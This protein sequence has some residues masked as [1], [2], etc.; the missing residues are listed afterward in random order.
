M[1]QAEAFLRKTMKIPI[2]NIE[3]K[4]LRDYSFV[5]KDYSSMLVVTGYYIH[6]VIVIGFDSSLIEKIIKNFLNVEE[7]HEN[8]KEELYLDASGEVINII[9]G[10]ANPKYIKN[11]NNLHMSTPVKVNSIDDII[12]PKWNSVLNEK[13]YTEYG[14]MDISIIEEIQKGIK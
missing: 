11:E 3:E 2:S 7:I 9:V 10:L 13:I 6:V 4:H 1:P 12:I 14:N 5:E 8:E